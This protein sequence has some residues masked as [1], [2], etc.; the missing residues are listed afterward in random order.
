MWFKY[1]DNNP[2][3]RIAYY[4]YIIS[5]TE[6]YEWFSDV[7]YNVYRTDKVDTE[8]PLAAKIFDGLNFKTQ[9]GV[10]ESY[11]PPGTIQPPAISWEGMTPQARYALN[12][13]VFGKDTYDQQCHFNDKNFQSSL[14]AAWLSTKEPDDRD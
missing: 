1:Q 13:F 6:G 9:F 11:P 2:N 10:F 5:F 4:P 3:G 8:V 12:T 14:Q 7:D